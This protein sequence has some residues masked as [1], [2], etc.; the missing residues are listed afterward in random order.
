MQPRYSPLNQFPHWITALCMLGLLPLAWVMV[1]AKHGAPHVEDLFNWHKTLGVIVLIVTAVRIVWRL[2]DPPPPYPPSV[3]SWE[4][5]VAHAIYW[6]FLA[7]LIW[8]PVTGILGSTF[9]G[10]AIKLFDAVPTPLLLA[11]DKRLADLFNQLHLLGQWA[12]Y[13]LIG[14]HLSAVAIHLIWR[15]DGLLGRMLP[16]NAAEPAA[17]GRR[18]PPLGAPATAGRR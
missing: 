18:A 6:L 4:R 9:G 2:R 12:V 14:L 1:N 13:A 7:T 15:R 10:H 8:M 17:Q 5:R 16:A 11:K 3:A